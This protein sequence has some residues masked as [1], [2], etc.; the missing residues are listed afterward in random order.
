M[1]TNKLAAEMISKSNT[2]NEINYRDCIF[3][4]M[5][6]YCY[7]EDAERVGIEFTD[8]D[9]DSFVTIKPD[10]ENVAKMITFANAIAF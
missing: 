6:L 5:G 7:R 10:I 3:Y 2:G 4:G 9:N 1:E 8:R